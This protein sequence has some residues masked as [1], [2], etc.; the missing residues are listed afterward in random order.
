[1]LTAL[2]AV[3]YPLSQSLAQLAAEAVARDAVQQAVE[4]IT[5]GRNDSV[6]SLQSNVLG[7]V[8]RVSLIVANPVDGE[9]VAE[10]ERLIL[11]RTG[12]E[13][14]LNVRRVAGEEELLRLREGLIRERPSALQDINEIRADLLARVQRP[15]DEL[16]P[17]SRACLNSYEVGF[18][19]SGVVV[20]VVYEADQNLSDDVLEVLERGLEARL[21]LQAVHLIAFNDVA[22]LSDGP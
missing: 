10:G 2:A 11:R 19:P 7:E 15:L 8:I 1:L 22:P 21:G 3:L 5:E 20:R 12:R 4:I 6:V 13:A 14:R 17:E 18:T 9:K 16:W